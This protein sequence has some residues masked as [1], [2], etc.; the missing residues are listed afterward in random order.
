MYINF[1]IPHRTVGSKTSCTHAIWQVYFSCTMS[2]EQW[3]L[4]AISL[5]GDRTGTYNTEIVTHQEHMVFFLS[6]DRL[7]A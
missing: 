6:G 1:F 4:Q 7:S 2:T 3:L 5:L